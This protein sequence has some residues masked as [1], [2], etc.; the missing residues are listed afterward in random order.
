MARP[1][2]DT[3]SPG[4]HRTFQSLLLPLSVRELQRCRSPHTLHAGGKGLCTYLLVWVGFNFNH[5]A[6]SVK[7]Q[8]H[9][10]K[11][12][13]HSAHRADGLRPH[14]PTSSMPW[15]LG[16]KAF[17]HDQKPTAP[18]GPL[19]L[20]PL[21]AWRDSSFRALNHSI[22]QCPGHCAPESIFHNCIVF[23]FVSHEIEP[24]DEDSVSQHI[25][26]STM[27]PAQNAGCNLFAQNSQ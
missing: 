6:R 15:T 12:V 10:K 20:S 4:C 11:S 7:S 22:S 17:P 16:P 14:P 18:L 25:P 21:P 27:L 19:G 8:N 2:L 9:W 3:K 1:Y 13:H 5:C 26:L 24:R 23:L